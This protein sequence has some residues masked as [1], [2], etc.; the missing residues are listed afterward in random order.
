MKL[1]A[2]TAPTLLRFVG[3]AMIVGTLA[4]EI[5]ERVLALTGV[6]LSLSV[7]PVGFDI[8]VLALWLMV[9]P[10]SLLAVVPGVLLFRRV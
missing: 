9:N 6:N 2:K 4:W 7:G 3:L 1:T 5:V 8:G 10:G